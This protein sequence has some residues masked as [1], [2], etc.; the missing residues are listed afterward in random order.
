MMKVP[1]SEKSGVYR[2]T[3][4]MYV[5][6]IPSPIVGSGVLVRQTCELYQYHT[7][8]HSRVAYFRFPAL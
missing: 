4:L 6:I 3:S 8:A 1:D 5:Q 7:L 2:V